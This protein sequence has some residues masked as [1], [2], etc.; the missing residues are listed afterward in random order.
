MRV[1]R[2][3]RPPRSPWHE[4]LDMCPADTSRTCPTT[5]AAPA[6]A[7]SLAVVA[8]YLQGPLS[9]GGPLSLPAFAALNDSLGFGIV[10]TSLGVLALESFA[11]AAA[12]LL[13]LA[14]RP[15]SSEGA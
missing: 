6:F 4:D 9:M 11:A 5:G 15:S 14:R 1:P 13:G 10:M 2:P 3:R 8:A 12:L 7:V